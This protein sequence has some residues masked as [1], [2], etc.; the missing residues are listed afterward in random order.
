M[1]AQ[2]SIARLRE[3]EAALRARGVCHPAVFGSRARGDNRPASDIIV[4]I[5]PDFPA[6]VYEYIWIKEYT[7]GLVDGRVDVVDWEGLKPYVRPS[8][9]ADA[10]YAFRPECTAPRAPWQLAPDRTDR[11]CVGP[12]R[13]VA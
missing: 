1:N 2:D 4:E 8:A 5:E 3:S 13:N 6:G 9:A 10:I 12:L 7:V 11:R